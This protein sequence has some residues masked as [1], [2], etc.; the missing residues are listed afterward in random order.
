MKLNRIKGFQL[1]EI[2]RWSKHH[3]SPNSTVIFDGF[4]GFN[5]VEKAQ[6][7][8]EQHIVGRGKDAVDKPYFK[9]VNTILGNLKNSLRGTYHAAKEKHIPRYLAEF[10]Y[11]FNRRYELESLVPRLAAIAVQ[12]PAMPDRLLTLADKER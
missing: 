7:T 4:A 6:C 3:L 8:H 1:T 2:E 12:T 11:R 5:A 10:Q 9:W